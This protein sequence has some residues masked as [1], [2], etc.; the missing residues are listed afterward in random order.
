MRGK[1]EIVSWKLNQFGRWRNKVLGKNS[2]LGMPKFYIRVKKKVS[3]RVMK[4]EAEK[5]RKVNEGAFSLR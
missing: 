4:K 5:I 2:D 1:N 3:I